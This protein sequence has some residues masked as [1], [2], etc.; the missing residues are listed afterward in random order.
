MVSER[1]ETKNERRRRR[2]ATHKNVTHLERERDREKNKRRERN[3][4]K[5]VQN[6]CM[7]K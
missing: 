7:N 2:W 3:T 6:G 5:W 1:Q 4:Q